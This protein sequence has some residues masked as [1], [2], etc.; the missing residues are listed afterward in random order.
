MPNIEAL[1]QLLRVAEAISPTQLDMRDFCRTAPS[2]GTVL[3]LAGHAAIDPWHRENTDFGKL[4]DVLE[5][6]YGVALWYRGDFNDLARIYD[7]SLEDAENL[8][9]GNLCLDDKPVP[10][11]DVLVNIKNLIDHGFAFQYDQVGNAD[12]GEELDDPP[13]D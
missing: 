2:C 1:Q 11:E 6:E 5:K 13:Q 8:F 3:C 4:S 12:Q 7:I 10:K 9:G